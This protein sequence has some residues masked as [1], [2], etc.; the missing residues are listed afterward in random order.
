MAVYIVILFV[1]R[2]GTILIA[3]TALGMKPQIN[4]VHL[5]FGDMTYHRQLHYK[6]GAYLVGCNRIN[7]SAYSCIVINSFIYTI[8]NLTRCFLFLFSNFNRENFLQP[9]FKRRFNR[10]LQLHLEVLFKSPYIQQLP[11][12]PFI[13]CFSPILFRLH[14][15]KRGQLELVE[16]AASQVIWIALYRDLFVDI[17]LL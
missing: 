11:S 1:C 14:F 2:S 17:V 5:L 9:L 4:T 10:R 12:K 15:P 13:K 3:L 16:N 7:S 6:V 8:G